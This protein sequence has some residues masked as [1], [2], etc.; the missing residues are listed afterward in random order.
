MGNITNK[1]PSL[2]NKNHAAA[3][4][5][6]DKIAAIVSEQFIAARDSNTQSQAVIVRQRDNTARG[7]HGGGGAMV[8]PVYVERAPV[9]ASVPDRKTSLLSGVHDL[10]SRASGTTNDTP[11]LPVARDQKGVMSHGMPG[12]KIT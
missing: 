2:T 1:I 7:A 8:S 11:P 5:T 9:I 12:G 3:L 4:A 6:Q 10:Q